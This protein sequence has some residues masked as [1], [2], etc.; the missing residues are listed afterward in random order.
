[1]KQI[2]NIGILLALLGAPLES[3][4]QDDG[5]ELR[6]SKKGIEIFTRTVE[7]SALDEAR[8]ITT[9]DASVGQLVA[10]L[11][12]VKN[13]V[14]WVPDCE[15]SELQRMESD[16]HTHYVEIKAPFPVKNR[17]G[18]YRYS[19]EIEEGYAKVKLEALPELGPEKEGKV[20]V[21]KTNGYWI[22]EALN[23][24]QTHVTYQVLADPGGSIPAW[25]ANAV[26]VNN[27]FETLEN[28]KTR[29]K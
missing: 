16:H 25:L 9:I 18:Y 26:V 11:K 14:K 24:Q 17:D 8:G 22:F 12:D 1:M 21:P 15:N 10:V 19:Y 5:W 29:V 7:G 27:P 6:R 23:N 3:V 2:L 28:L 13:Y 4:G 20:R